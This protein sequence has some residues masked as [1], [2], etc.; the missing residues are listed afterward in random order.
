MSATAA[1]IQDAWDPR[2]AVPL[3]KVTLPVGTRVSPLTAEVTVILNVTA[4]PRSD[5][6]AEEVGVVV[7]LVD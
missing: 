3:L 1:G 4:C 6:L 7:E 5:G 2:T